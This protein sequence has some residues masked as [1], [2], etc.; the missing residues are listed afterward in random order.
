MLTP[1]PT[2]PNFNCNSPPFLIKI[3]R[4]A[5]NEK[6]IYNNLYDDFSNVDI[7]SHDF[8]IFSNTCIGTSKVYVKLTLALLGTFMH[9]HMLKTK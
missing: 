1:T 9:V 3:K 2:K 7:N 8:F 5:N 4:R 6:I